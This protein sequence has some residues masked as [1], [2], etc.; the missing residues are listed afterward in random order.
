MGPLEIHLQQPDGGQVHA[1]ERTERRSGAGMRKE[2][3]ASLRS[4]ARCVT[5]I[6]AQSDKLVPPWL[7]CIALLHESSIRPDC[8]HE[9]LRPGFRNHSHSFKELES[10]PCLLVL[11]I[12]HRCRRRLTIRL[13]LA[14]NPPAGFGQMRATAVAA[15]P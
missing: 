15:L 10:P 13:F 2:A 6:L 7:L 11:G 12:R 1:G 3:R 8:G 4:V 9:H 5:Y 14:E